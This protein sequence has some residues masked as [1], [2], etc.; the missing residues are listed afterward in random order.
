MKHTPLLRQS[1]AISRMGIILPVTLLAAVQT[2]H[3]VELDI[4]DEKDFRVSSSVLP[5]VATSTLTPLFDSAYE[6]LAT[7]LCSM[8]D[9]TILSPGLSTPL[10][11]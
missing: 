4:S 1:A 8:D 9:I 3:L 11:A 6:G 10:M 5:M 7:E 2:T